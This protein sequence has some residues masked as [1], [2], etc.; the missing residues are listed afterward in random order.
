MITSGA[1]SA[2]RS[3]FLDNGQS[4]SM[5]GL[6]A[7]RKASDAF[8]TFISLKLYVRAPRSVH[9]WVDPFNKP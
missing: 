4:M 9:C 3:P 1:R 2:E 7:G 5:S 8:E 6:P